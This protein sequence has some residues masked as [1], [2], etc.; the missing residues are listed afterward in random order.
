[1][2]GLVACVL[3]DVVFALWLAENSSDTGKGNDTMVAFYIALAA[4][5][6]YAIYCQLQMYR[7]EGCGL[8]DDDE[9]EEEEGGSAPSASAQAQAQAEAQAAAKAAAAARA[10]TAGG[11]KTGVQ[12]RLTAGNG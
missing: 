1:M 7:E 10:L 12:Q 8:D 4:L 3:G 6:I 2:M 9:E 5:A 11:E